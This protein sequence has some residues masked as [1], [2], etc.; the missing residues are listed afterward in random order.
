MESKQNFLFE[1]KAVRF[2]QP[3]IATINLRPAE[4]QRY[5]TQTQK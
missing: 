3:N 5:F 4:T 1:G 2:I